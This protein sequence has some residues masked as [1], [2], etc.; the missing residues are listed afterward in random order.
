MNAQE[1]KEQWKAYYDAWRDVYKDKKRVSRGDL[2][3]LYTMQDQAFPDIWFSYDTFADR[4]G[5]SRRNVI[6]RMKH[7]AEIGCVHKVS[8]RKKTSTNHY[9]LKEDLRDPNKDWSQ[10]EKL[11]KQTKKTRDYEI[12]L[13]S[14]EASLVNSTSPESE[15]EFTS[16]SE[17]GFTPMYKNNEK[18]ERDGNGVSVGLRPNIDNNYVEIGRHVDQNAIDKDAPSNNCPTVVN[19]DDVPEIKLWKTYIPYWD[20]AKE[21]HISWGEVY[22]KYQ[23]ARKSWNEGKRYHAKNIFELTKKFVNVAIG[24]GHIEPIQESIYELALI[25]LYNP[26][27]L[28][29]EQMQIL[30]YRRQRLESEQKGAD[31]REKS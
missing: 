15:V 26:H 8:G 28:I 4:T 6:E 19:L 17:A 2:A 16:A 12:Q 10:V 27:R 21:N 5:Q 7:L 31:S 9:F 25:D 22:T 23:E 1:M 3:I 20:F 24:Y 30:E 13:T 11:L 29:K 18:K 14:K